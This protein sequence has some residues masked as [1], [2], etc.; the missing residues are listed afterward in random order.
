MLHINNYNHETVTTIQLYN[1]EC[2][3]Q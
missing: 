1:H 3:K 2:I